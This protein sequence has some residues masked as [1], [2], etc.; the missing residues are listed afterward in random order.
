MAKR[1]LDPEIGDE[2]SFT[3][4][5][6]NVKKGKVIAKEQNGYMAETHSGVKWRFHKQDI[7]A[8]E[9]SSEDTAEGNS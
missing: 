6:G 9:N 2:V 5:D 4:R 1:N 8:N 7:V 3:A